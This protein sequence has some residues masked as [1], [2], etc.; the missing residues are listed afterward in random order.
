MQPS[1]YDRLL[2]ILCSV[3]DAYSAVVF[4]PNAD[5]GDSEA[6]SHSIA[7]AFS[8]GQKLN[9]R[10]EIVEGRGLVGWLLRNRE[11]LF[12][13]NFDRHQHKLGY[14]KNNEEANIKAFMGCPLPGEMGAICVDSK[15]QYSFSEKDQKVLHLFADLIARLEQERSG[16]QDS[17][18]ALKYYAALSTIY[19]LRRRHSRWSEFLRYLLDLMT[20]VTGFSYSALFTLDSGNER[21]RLEGE[22]ITVMARKQPSPSFPI[23]HGI[24]GWVFR[25]GVQVCSDGPEGSPDA[26][27]VGRGEDVPQFQS[28]VALPIIMQKK[29]RGVLCLAHDEPVAIHQATQDFA[30]MA[31]EHLSLFLE[32]LYLK[33]RLRDLHNES[34]SR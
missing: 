22:N 32:N 25:N 6:H 30:R 13:S 8:L 24:I 29:T 7:A 9:H 17:Q 4:L 15:R 16:K 28:V 19:T 34:R 21:Y 26:M 18:L 20:T 27:L 11:P 1:N 23:S 3:L 33:C 10:A 12:V 31:S 5:P 2:A 14:Y